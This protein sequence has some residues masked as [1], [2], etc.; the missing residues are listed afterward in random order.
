MTPRGAR[1]LAR[2]VVLRA[3]LDAMGVR[4]ESH[5]DPAKIRAAALAFV[6]AAA[7]GGPEGLWFE[8]AGIDPAAVMR[9]LAAG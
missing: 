2:A 4:V 9:R 1:R 6:A 8:V 5:E 7:R 3:A